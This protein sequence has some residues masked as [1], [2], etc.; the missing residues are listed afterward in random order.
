MKN[1]SSTISSIFRSCS[2]SS[3]RLS[4]IS[5]EERQQHAAKAHQ[6]RVRSMSPA[7][8]RRQARES[9][10]LRGSTLSKSYLSSKGGKM[11]PEAVISSILAE[12]KVSDVLCSSRNKSMQNATIINQER[13]RLSCN[14]ETL[15]DG[16]K[17]FEPRMV[18]K[19]SKRINSRDETT[20]EDRML[21]S[22][23]EYRIKVKVNKDAAAVTPGPGQYS[24]T[25][26]CNR[27]CPLPRGRKRGGNG[28]SGRDGSD[29]QDMRSKSPGA[30]SYSFSRARRELI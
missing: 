28:G 14:N 23:D 5:F 12:G 29:S 1:R 9:V 7:M 26:E 8:Q 30:G 4:D 6:H 25:Q 3:Y 10:T 13:K 22:M 27:C 16:G 11:Y 20:F 2:P 21:K 24:N 17:M 15:S 18:S 19:E